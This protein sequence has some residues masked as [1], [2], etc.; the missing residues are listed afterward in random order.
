MD[1]TPV[2]TVWHPPQNLRAGNHE[3]IFRQDKVIL[4]CNTYQIVVGLTSEARSIQQITHGRLEI[5]GA[6]ADERFQTTSG[7]GA[8]LNSMTTLHR[9]L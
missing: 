8:V 6:P 9:E 2:Q 1:G 5:S 3:F 7:V 4:A